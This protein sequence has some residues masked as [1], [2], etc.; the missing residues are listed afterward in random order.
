MPVTYDASGEV[1][2]IIC[3]PEFTYQEFSNA[4]EAAMSDPGFSPETPFLF[5]YQLY[6]GNI[7]Q[8]VIRTRAHY[9]GAL[10][11]KISSRIAILVSDPFHYGLGRMFQVYTSNY[12][13]QIEIFTDPEQAEKFLLSG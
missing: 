12:G 1:I 6:T 3:G 13:Y 5:D 4:I 2:R 11:G 10:K 9:L 7:P 8:G